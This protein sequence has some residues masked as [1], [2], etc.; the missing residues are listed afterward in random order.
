MDD[1]SPAGSEPVVAV[2]ERS[3]LL[4]RSRMES[5]PGIGTDRRLAAAGVSYRWDPTDVGF[6]VEG[7][8]IQGS[9]GTREACRG[10]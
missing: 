5:K 2:A 4:Q 10:V 1:Q 6:G 9:A 8:C 7:P 3:L